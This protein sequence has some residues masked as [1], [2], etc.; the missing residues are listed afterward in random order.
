M[1]SLMVVKVQ[2]IH[3]VRRGFNQVPEPMEINHLSLKRVIK[4]FHICIVPTTA[5]TTLTDQQIM[6]IEHGIQLFVRELRTSI[7]MKYG[8]L[9]WLMILQCHQQGFFGQA[10]IAFSREAPTNNLPRI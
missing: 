7:S 10:R 3:D 6:F 8:A 2:V 5:F 4:R 9:D 1:Q